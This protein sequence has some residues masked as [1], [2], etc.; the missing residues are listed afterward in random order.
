MVTNLSKSKFGDFETFEILERPFER[1][2]LKEASLSSINGKEE[3]NERNNDGKFVF[4]QANSDGRWHTGYLT[5]C[6]KF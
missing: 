2:K 3:E 6:T 5:F 4:G 1:R